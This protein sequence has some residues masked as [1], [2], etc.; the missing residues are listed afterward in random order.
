MKSLSTFN[1][2]GS[3]DEMSLPQNLISSLSSTGITKPTEIQCQAIPLAI[4]GEDLIAIAQTGSGKTLAFAIPA[5]V[6]LSKNPNSRIL[7]LAPSRE[8]AGQIHKVMSSLLSVTVNI[9]PCLVIGGIPNAKQVS[10]L[11][12]LPRVIIATPGRMKD[13]LITNKLLLQNV[14]LLIIDEADRMLDMGFTPQLEYI[15]RTLRGQR[16]TLMFSASFAKSVEDIA[17][18]FLTSQAYLI[19]THRA[20][21]PVE[22]LYQKLLFINK[23]DKNDRLLDELNKTKNG[24]IVFTADQERCEFV[25][26]H[27][28]EF[29]YASDLIHGGLSQGHRNRV[30]REFRAGTTRILV[31]TDL[32]ARG[33]DVPHVDTVINFDLPFQ[34]EDFLHRIGRTARAGQSGQAITFITPEDQKRF[35]PIKEYTAGA[36]EEKVDPKF[37]WAKKYKPDRFRN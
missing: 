34:S 27:L 8:M 35:R 22:K 4:H 7:I 36:S 10:H 16:Q 30:V 3:F 26:K 32:L 1:K 20:E 12:K 13:H 6:K 17:S 5:I 18:H 15:K 37:E 28:S 2:F 29:G 31:A 23:K 24:V 33:L 9:E 25:G 14:D 11:K 21:K 19:R